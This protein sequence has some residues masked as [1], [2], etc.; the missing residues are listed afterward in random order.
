MSQGAKFGWRKLLVNALVWTVITSIC[1]VLFVWH[2]KGVSQ[3]GNGLSFIGTMSLLVPGYNQ[4][5]IN[6]NYSSYL[7]EGL[8]G[9]LKRFENQL[10]ANR[11]KELL[12]FSRTDF[13]CFVYGI[14]LTAAGFLINIVLAPTSVS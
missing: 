7:G 14:I 13:L 2:Q 6:R 3:I 11:I 5:R 10:E 8:S 9:E 12:S 1:V 4:L